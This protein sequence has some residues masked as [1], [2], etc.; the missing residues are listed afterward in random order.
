MESSSDWMTRA[1]AAE[2][3]GVSTRQ[4]DRLRLPRVMLGSHPRYSRRGLD[5]YLRERSF[6]PAERDK[7]GPKP[8]LRV[9]PVRLGPTD[10]K[11]RLKKLRR[12]LRY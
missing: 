11:E 2:Y 10:V 5:E 3:L 9:G 7:G 6:T 1:R 8:P 4:I 12:E